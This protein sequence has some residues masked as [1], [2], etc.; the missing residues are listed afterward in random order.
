VSGGTA[1]NLA[2]YKWGY[3]GIN[4]YNS[5]GVQILNNEI[6]I[7]GC[8]TPDPSRKDS[9]GLG[10]GIELA[11]AE[12]PGLGNHAV[13]GNYVQRA[14][15]EG[16]TIIA[17]SYNQVVDNRIENSQLGIM[18]RPG[19]SNVLRNNALTRVG[20]PSY[21]NPSCNES[22]RYGV[23]VVLQGGSTRNDIIG[24]VITDMTHSASGDPPRHGITLAPASMGE[25]ANNRALYNTITWSLR[26]SNSNTAGIWNGIKNAPIGIL[27]DWGRTAEVKQNYLHNNAQHL[28]GPTPSPYSCNRFD[29]TLQSGCSIT[30]GEAACTLIGNAQSTD[31]YTGVD[32]IG[33]EHVNSSSPY[34]FNATGTRGNSLRYGITFPSRRTKSGGCLNTSTYL[35]SAY[36]VYR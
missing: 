3:I 21:F 20:G 18:L 6:D 28:Y 9:C 15:F 32:C 19:H 24:T 12:S 2:A 33:N 34:T 14:E 31:Y 17:S 35:S 13:R 36:Q 22:T 5:N 1:S 8:M 10:G 29:G 27:V 4:V 26:P 16:I 11:N 25:Q 30:C 7:D 23:G